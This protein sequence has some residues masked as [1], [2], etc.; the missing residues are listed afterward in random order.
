MPAFLRI[1]SFFLLL[2]SYTN[3]QVYTDPFFP[4]A[5]Q[6]V[7]IYYDA[8][9]G[10]GG[11]ANC[12]CNI[13]LHTGLITSASTAPNDWKH[14]VT[15]WGTANPAWQMTPVAGQPNLYRF[16]M[17]TSIRAFYNAPASTNILKMAFVFRNASGSLEGKATG[18]ADI[19][20]DVYPANLPFT[21]LLLQPTNRTIITTAGTNIPI[22]MVS[23]APA[24]IRVLDNG[25]LLTQTNGTELN[26]TLNA[27]SGTHTIEVIADNG[28]NQIREVF[29]Y[30]VPATLTPLNPPTGTERGIT[31]LGD[32][33]VRLRLFAPNK[34]YAFV[35]GS[36]NDWVPQ[37][38]NRS[39]D[40]NNYWIDI[41]GLTP[42]NFYTFQYILDGDI[43][44]ADPYSTLVLDPAHD[45]WIPASTW[46]G[47]PPY[48][49]GRAAG[50]VTLIQPGAPTYQWQ[51]NDFQR[52]PTEKLVIYELL[53]RDFIGARNYNTL[54]DTLDYL[55]RLGVNVIQLMPVNEFE[56]NSSWGYN[57]SFHMALDKYY[58]KPND[59]KRFVD[60]CHQR[61]IAV[62]LDVVYNHAFG[63]SPL[64]QLY[65]DAANN[66]PAA[67]NPWL[68]PIA[69][70][71]F[72]VGFDF[73]HAQQATKDFVTQ[74]MQYWLREFRIDGFRFDL[75]KGFTQT[76]N[77]D[78][79]A[80]SAYDAS[81]IQILKYYVD[82]VWE[83][84]PGAYCIMEHFGANNEEIELSNYG[85][86]LWG[87]INYEFNEGTMG[88]NSNLSWASHQSRGWSA[89][90]LVSY[91][92]SHDEERLMYKNLQFG[93]IAGT[94]NVRQLNTAL[95]RKELGAV[96][97]Y[98][99][100]GPKM[101]WQFGELGYDFSI[102]TCENGT[103]NPNDTG[104]KL[105]PKP[106]RWDYY[107]NSQR[108]RLFD[109]TAAMIHLKKTYAAFSTTNTVLNIGTGT[110]KT[111][112]LLHPEMNVAVMGNFNVV[113]NQILNPFPHTGRWY[114]Y[115]TGDSIDVA[116]ASSPLTFAPGEYRL[117]TSV[118]LPAPPSGYL[119]SNTEI[120]R[121]VFNL[122]VFPNPSPGGFGQLVF[123]LP[124]AAELRVDIL[125]ITGRNIQKGILQGLI[126]GGEHWVELPG[127]LAPGVYLIRLQVENQV[128][129][130]KWIVQ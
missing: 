90:R 128:E 114:E 94:Y 123:N 3:A 51:T 61:G 8:S 35:V 58:G 87:N 72:N 101:L 30:A 42:G 108:R 111:I 52:P 105:S 129:V 99:I 9:Q 28:T 46:P 48:P 5:D 116:N 60:E 93:N 85:M 59:L 113:Q 47:L 7:T 97:L 33:A 79:N 10:T 22:R 104:C 74:V 117:Y 57:P 36:F 2:S 17:P 6:P 21:A 73:N 56:G 40:G 121:D 107:Q 88:Y 84:T 15:T 124:K 14:V 41:S 64:V 126:Q 82:R 1:L 24:N 75:S 4:R 25:N 16:T 130:Q 125:D 20:Y 110:R 119:T 112:H 29:G 81:R 63:Q 115:F 12:N 89:P 19:F 103:V 13:Y 70:H 26:Y 66:R 34:S 102:F 55:E 78:V 106:I 31:Y 32:T 71:P 43:R 67:N 68:N 62:V 83:V 11:L 18:G 92:E 122:E 77:T 86:M 95:R 27:S 127:N 37:Q 50:V 45:P 23:S 65:W 39:A 91:M 109:V 38:M 118:R 69:R 80:W 120:V 53:I 54:T 98:S 76:F 96:F 44:I 100:P 49:S